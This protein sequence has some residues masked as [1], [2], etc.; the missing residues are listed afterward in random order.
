M[1]SGVYSSDERVDDDRQRL[2]NMDLD[3]CGSVVRAQGSR[4][5]R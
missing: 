4:P 1:V 2:N 3:M 5:R